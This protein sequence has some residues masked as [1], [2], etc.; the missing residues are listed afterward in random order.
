MWMNAQLMERVIILVLIF[1]EGFLV[2]VIR[3][4]N[5]MASRTVEVCFKQWPNWTC[6]LQLDTTNITQGWYPLALRIIM[7]LYIPAATFKT[8]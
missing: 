7:E 3:D 8:V 5:S 4:I 2:G 6:R 1:L